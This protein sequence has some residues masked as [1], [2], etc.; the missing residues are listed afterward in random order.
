M[1]DFATVELPSSPNA[2]LVC[3]AEYC[4]AAEAQTAS[5]VI[6]APAASVRD[7]WMAVVAE[8]PRTKQEAADEAAL[9]YEFVQRS[10]LFR[11][12]DRITVRFIPLSETTSTVLVFSRSKF[13]YSDMGVNKKRVD[14]WLAQT[15]AKVEGAP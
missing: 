6:P 14:S 1:I 12:P 7:A 2:Y 4:Q 11:F 3:T 15:V 13:G 9:Q 5:P 8:A 10:A